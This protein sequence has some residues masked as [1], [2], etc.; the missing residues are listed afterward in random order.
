M[1]RQHR[2]NHVLPASVSKSTVD[3]D[4]NGQILRY[5]DLSKKHESQN[6][7][8]VGDWQLE[9]QLKRSFGP[10]GVSKSLERRA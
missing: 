8:V 6:F 2:S 1:K 3:L 7:L 4:F 10:N 5:F 9:N